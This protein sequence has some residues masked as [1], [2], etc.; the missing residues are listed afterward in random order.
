MTMTLAEVTAGLEELGR[1]HPG[2]IQNWIVD[3]GS[4][5]YLHLRR[6]LSVTVIV[7]PKDPARTRFK[8][9][10]FSKGTGFTPV[11]FR[12]GKREKIIFECKQNGAATM[13]DILPKDEPDFL[14]LKTFMRMILDELGDD[15]DGSGPLVISDDELPEGWGCF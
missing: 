2:K 13:V 5:Y 14:E 9:M 6:N 10:A 15:T 4:H 12:V 1:K 7:D 3:N 8:K 11:G